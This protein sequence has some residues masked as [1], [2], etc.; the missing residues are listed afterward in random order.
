M[1]IVAFRSRLRSREMISA[2]LQL[3]TSFSSFPFELAR[4]FASPGLTATSKTPFFSSVFLAFTLEVFLDLETFVLTEDVDFFCF[5]GGENCE[6]ESSAFPAESELTTT[7]GAL[8]LFIVSKRMFISFYG[9][10]IYR[11][12]INQISTRQADG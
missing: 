2:G 12:L 4:F 5:F 8:T 1:V 6:S 10:N 7:A 3:Q 9:L 11:I